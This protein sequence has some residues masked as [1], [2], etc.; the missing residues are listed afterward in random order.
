MLQIKHTLTLTLNDSTTRVGFSVSRNEL[1]AFVCVFVCVRVH[2]CAS[3]YFHTQL[4]QKIKIKGSWKL[5][6]FDPSLKQIKRL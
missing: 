5:L 2:V 1:R 3:N 6:N 4:L